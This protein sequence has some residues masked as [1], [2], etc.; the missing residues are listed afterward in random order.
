MDVAEKLAPLIELQKTHPDY[1][2]SIRFDDGADGDVWVY[3]NAHPDPKGHERQRYLCFVARPDDDI[4]AEITQHESELAE[5][6]ARAKTQAAEIFQRESV[7]LHAEALAVAQAHAEV[8]YAQETTQHVAPLAEQYELAC[9]HAAKLMAKA[10]HAA[11]SGENDD[12]LA[13]LTSKAELD[14]QATSLKAELDAQIQAVAQSKAIYLASLSETMTANAAAQ[15]AKDNAQREQCI[16]DSPP[17]RLTD[18]IAE[19]HASVGHLVAH[20]SD[21]PEACALLEP[22]VITSYVQEQ[23]SWLAQH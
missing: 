12:A 13:A 21:A 17:C 20:R 8:F 10:T 11:K 6:F 4:A 14:D 18:R 22:N 5:W 3:V 16:D 15:A 23:M 9:T 1:V 7:R 19:L 2:H